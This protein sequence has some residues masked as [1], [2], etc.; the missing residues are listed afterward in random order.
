MK[1]QIIETEQTYPLRHLVLRPG[2]PIETCYF[3]GD[4][5]F[6]T[7]HIGLY[8]KDEIQ[9]I[10]SFRKKSHEYFSEDNQ[11]QL[12]GMAT[13]PEKRGQGLGKLI[14]E[15]GLKLFKHDLIWCNARISAR[16][17]YEKFGFKSH[18]EVFEIPDVGPHIIMSFNIS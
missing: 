18:G 3:D 5:D 9:C 1:V 7:V 2:R 4:Q 11:Y 16:G 10:V 6:D 15:E 17:F 12:R 13:H 14:I 8:E